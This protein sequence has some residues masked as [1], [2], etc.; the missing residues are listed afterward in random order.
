[1]AVVNLTPLLD[2]LGGTV[3]STAASFRA[4]A[5][6]AGRSAVRV[7]AG[8]VTF[9]TEITAAWTAAGWDAL[10]QL[11][12]LPADCYWSIRI[13][14]AGTRLEG[15]YILPTTADEV[16]FGDLIAVIPETAQPDT[17]TIAQ[18]QATQQFVANQVTAINATASTIF[19]TVATVQAQIG[20][21][22]EAAQTAAAAADAAAAAQ[23]SL[24]GELTTVTDSAAA[25][26]ASATEA[27]GSASTAAG[28][29][30]AAAT[31]AATASSAAI[32]AAADRAALE[33]AITDFY[34]TNTTIDGN[35]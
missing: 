4:V 21:A 30:S 1:M 2:T 9:P 23:E 25:A 11:H 34:A 28:S 32:A 18:F 13:A 5:M 33:A 26:A 7:T 35:A 22:T 15:A 16:D 12:T 24:A 17:S 20:T 8:T 10:P 27:A 6:R 29:A 31:S 19:G 3:T 14:A